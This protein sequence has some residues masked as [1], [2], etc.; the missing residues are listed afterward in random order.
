MRKSIYQ[1]ISP[2]LHGES[3]SSYYEGGIVVI[4]LLSLLPLT[5]KE[6]N[7]FYRELERLTS[8]VFII[9]YLLRWLTAD[10]LL[11]KGKWSFCFYPLTPLAIIDLISFLPIV[12]F[13]HNSLRVLKIFRLTRSL[14][15]LRMIRHSKNI[16]ILLRV[17]KN[18]KDS[19]LL[20]SVLAL[21]YIVVSALMMFTIEPDRF[22][23]FLDALYWSTITL[24]TIGYGDIYAQTDFGKILTMVSAFIGIGVVALPAGIITAGY[25]EEVREHN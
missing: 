6:P 8:L 11:K 13:L 18:Q 1:M 23:H 12:S 22:N 9:D 17:L 25:L 21:A 7:L 10:Y 4:I 15:V 2:K 3:R 24:T 20:V 5:V 16:S 19:L 14:R